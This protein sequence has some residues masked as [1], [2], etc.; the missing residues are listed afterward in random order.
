MNIATSATPQGVETL[1]FKGTLVTICL[2][3]QAGQDGISVLEH[4]MPFGESPPLHIHRNEDEVF[5]ILEGTM[6]FHL[7][8]KDII[9]HS[10]ETV[11][12]PKGLPH[13]FRVESPQGARCLTITA[14]RDFE[15]VVRE[16]GD[17]AGFAGLPPAMEP[18]PEM[19]AAL[20]KCCARNGI[21]VVGAPLS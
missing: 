2:S 19:I 5:H 4:T 12:A 17:P 16:M 11:I 7:D 14:G 18:T 10:G 9:R 20:V 3:S 1:W 13:S 8:G 21:D 15:Q 6:R